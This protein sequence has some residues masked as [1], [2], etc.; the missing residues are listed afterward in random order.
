MLLEL[1]QSVED[2]A[3]LL[4]CGANVS[5][6]S[7]YAAEEEVLFPPMTMLRVVPRN[8][9]AKEKFDFDVPVDQSGVED[10]SSS[11]S[12]SG[13]DGSD[14]ENSRPGGGAKL[15]PAVRLLRQP[16]LF[17]SARHTDTDSA[18][19]CPGVYVPAMEADGCNW[20]CLVVVWSNARLRHC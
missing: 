3:G 15:M 12:G 18:M 10:F 16:G 17:F 7:Q 5:L 20:S 4:H 8:E 11:G 19:H 13:S 6:I 9:L 2:S 14:D 1:R